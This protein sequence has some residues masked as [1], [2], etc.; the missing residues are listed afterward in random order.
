MKTILI[1]DE[2]AALDTLN[3]LLRLHCP[4]VEVEASCSKP[5]AGIE[6]IQRLQPELVF[7]DIH[8]PEMNGFQLLQL[9][10]DVSFKVIFTT[11][12]EGYAVQAFKESALDYLLKPIISSDLKAAVEKARRAIE[13]ESG[14]SI[15]TKIAKF[16]DHR[17]KSDK[18]LALPLGE[19]FVPV[20]AEEIIRCQSD[21]NYTHIILQSGKKI[22]LSKTL[23]VIEEILVGFPFFRI[24]QTHLINLKHISKVVKGEN[25]YLVS[26][27][28]EIL[29]IARAR[30]DAFLTLFQRL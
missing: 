15:M 17:I 8:M 27:D 26:S 25:P 14:D 3:A 19:G 16:M 12:H 24:H 10:R 13:I 6:A 11:A 23:A 18:I 7:L 21:G 4:G 28:G 20:A 1:D 5:E 9:T 30:K 22:T 29:P 2:P